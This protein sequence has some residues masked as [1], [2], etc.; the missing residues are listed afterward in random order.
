MTFS[1]VPEEQQLMTTLDQP[2][3][4]VRRLGSVFLCSETESVLYFVFVDVAFK[5]QLVLDFMWEI[6]T[7]SIRVIILLNTYNDLC[8]RNIRGQSLFLSGY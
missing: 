3:L 6:K 7:L 2:S 8:R 4:D 5:G 1:H